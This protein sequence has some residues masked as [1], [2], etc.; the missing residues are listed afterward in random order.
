MGYRHTDPNGASQLGFSLAQAT[1]RDGKRCSAAKAYLKSVVADRRNLHISMNSWVTKILIDPQ[2]KVA[3]GVEFLKNK[4]KYFIR[5][6]KEVILSAG[7]IASPQLLM[8][9]GIGPKEHLKEMGIPVIKDL[10]VGYNLQDHPQLSGLTFTVEKP[11]TLL[12]RDFHDPLIPLEYF[13]RGKGP[14][15]VPGGA[16]G[17]AFIKTNTTFNRM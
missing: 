6:K 7:T 12:E 3:Y 9:S 10:K 13:L 8:L 17:I 1:L 5:A 2:T 11:V 16:E 4:K 14:L 15:T